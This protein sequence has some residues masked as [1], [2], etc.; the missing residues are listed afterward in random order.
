[1]AQIPAERMDI[2][3][4]V[5]LYWPLGICL[6]GAFVGFGIVPRILSA[7]LCGAMLSAGME[8]LQI[9]L[10]GRLVSLGDFYGNSA[11]AA[12]GALTGA[13]VG[14]H[15]HAPWLIAVKRRPFACLMLCSWL[16]SGFFLASISVSPLAWFE[17]GV[18][19]L[20][21]A[22]LIEAVIRGDR[23]SLLR[24]VLPWIA[25]LFAIHVCVDALRPFHFLA[26]AR[27]FGWAPFLSFLTASRE[28]AIRSFF[29]KAFMYGTLPWLAV[30]AGWRLERAAAVSTLLVL[31]LRIAQIYLPGR[32]A[33]ITDAVMVL[34]LA[35]VKKLIE[36]S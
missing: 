12:L 28:S 34:G 7:V 23:P 1:M 19:W 27:P 35:C 36:E 18:T 21:V 15:S 5:L 20:A 22:A 29:E 24:R 2:V 3:S 32:S 16:G 33:E 8:S 26:Q 30:R 17:R 4:N 10:P 25:L 6:V 31:A 9:F 11:G 13:L 14:G